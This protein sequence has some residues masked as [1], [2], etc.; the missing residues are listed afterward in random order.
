MQGEHGMLCGT[1]ARARS[2]D[3]AENRGVWE[4]EGAW[5][6]AL[7]PVDGQCIFH[8]FTHLQN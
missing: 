3:A 5:L 6:A 1:R 2:G 8:G 7:H 4:E